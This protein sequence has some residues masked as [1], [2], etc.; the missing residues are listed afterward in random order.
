MNYAT[1]TRYDAILARAGSAQIK[2]AVV[3]LLVAFL[4]V[5][6]MSLTGLL[7]PPL[8]EAGEDEAACAATLLAGGVVTH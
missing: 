5:A 4:I 3:I 1:H 7:D 2:R 8:T 6:A